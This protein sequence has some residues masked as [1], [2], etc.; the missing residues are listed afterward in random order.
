M[1]K[2]K[3]GY[4]LS[5]PNRSSFSLLSPPLSTPG[6]QAISKYALVTSLQ[7]MQMNRFSIQRMGY[8]SCFL[9]IFLR[10]D[11]GN[12]IPRERERGG[13]RVGLGIQGRTMFYTGR[14]CPEVK[15]LTLLY[16][17]F[18]GKGTFF[19]YLLVRVY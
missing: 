10:H 2:S 5:F 15:P 17:I 12:F 19:V 18:V 13:G 14:F 1:E 3:K 8:F 16:T 7:S 4:F 11:L 6:T 9:T